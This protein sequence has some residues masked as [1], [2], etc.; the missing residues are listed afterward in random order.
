MLAPLARLFHVIG[1]YA[2]SKQLL[3]HALELWKEQGDDFLGC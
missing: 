3:T 1:N 2:E